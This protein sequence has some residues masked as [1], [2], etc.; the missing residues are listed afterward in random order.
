MNIKQFINDFENAIENS[1]PED[2]PYWNG[3]LARLQTMVYE[4][5]EVIVDLESQ[6]QSEY[7]LT[8]SN[9]DL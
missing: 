6:L 4:A 1:N 7:I 9:F 3:E 2:T 5:I 8:R